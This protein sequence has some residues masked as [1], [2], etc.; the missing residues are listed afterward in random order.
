MMTL[1][2]RRRSYPFHAWRL[3]NTGLL[4]DDDGQSGHDYDG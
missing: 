1:L 4:A 2:S 3:R